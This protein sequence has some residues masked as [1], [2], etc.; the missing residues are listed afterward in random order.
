MYQKSY[1]GVRDEKDSV[2]Y[3]SG[4]SDR[5]NDIGSRLRNEGNA[6]KS[7]SYNL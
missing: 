4:S 6:E 3:D 7:G 5:W 1:G 2:D